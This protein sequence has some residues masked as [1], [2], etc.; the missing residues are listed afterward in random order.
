[1]IGNIGKEVFHIKEA[2]IIPNTKKIRML[3]LKNTGTG[4][5]MDGQNYI[6]P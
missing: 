6:H 4:G 2:L 1:V 3:C 5:G